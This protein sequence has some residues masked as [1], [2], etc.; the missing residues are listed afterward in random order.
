MRV[1]NGLFPAMF[2][3]LSL[4]N[5]TALA[6]PESFQDAEISQHGEPDSLVGVPGGFEAVRFDPPFRAPFTIDKIRFEAATRDGSPI[7]FPS[8][9]LVEFDTASRQLLWNT[10]LFVAAP[11]ASSSGEVEIPA[12][13]PVSDSGRVFF[14]CFEFPLAD[15]AS[16]SFPLLR[17]DLKDMESGVFGTSYTLDSV[18]HPIPQLDRNVVASIV[19][20]VSAGAL[21]GAPVNMG[22]N[23]KTLTEFAFRF[24]VSERERHKVARVNLLRQEGPVGAWKVAASAAV[25][26]TDEVTLPARMFGGPLWALQAE[27]AEGNLSVSSNVVRTDLNSVDAFEPNGSP[28]HASAIPGITAD[29]TIYPPGDEDFYSVMA[30]PG[31]V[32]HVRAV[33]VLPGNGI[34][35]L[36]LG[37]SLVDDRDHIIASDTDSYAGYPDILYSVR[38]R[39]GEGVRR[40]IVKVQDAR[41]SKFASDTAPV[42]LDHLKI[43]YI[44]AIQV[45]PREA[46]AVADGRV[47]AASTISA[48]PGGGSIEFSL[49]AGLEDQ[50]A[51]VRIYDVRGHLIKSLET[52]RGSLHRKVN[53]DGTDRRGRHLA[54]G[55]SY[56]A[57]AGPTPQAVMKIIL[58]R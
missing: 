9:R 42:I 49:P 2:I 33:P 41:G 20:Q 3:L 46:R 57:I 19:C 11:F 36:K 10:P 29:A 37:A 26:S 12:D 35:D 30:G 1:S 56:V 53:W 18:H 28:D 8:V 47:S 50:P 43:S 7:V 16:P 13:V 32:I 45:S 25:D 31:D 21:L 6:L 27:D 44:V 14:V 39:P 15:P 40:Y 22:V 54:R 23:W 34:N 5:G 58:G 51:P 52:M 17:A 4:W 48:V 24:K 38:G 55:L